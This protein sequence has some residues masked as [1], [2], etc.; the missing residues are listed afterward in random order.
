M[1]SP[2]LIRFR[3]IKC[4]NS[5]GFAVNY[6]PGPDPSYEQTLTE[7]RYMIA[8]LLISLCRHFASQQAFLGLKP[9]HWG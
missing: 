8:A 3:I 5:V 6:E 1:N 4:K 9:D 2:K 7:R